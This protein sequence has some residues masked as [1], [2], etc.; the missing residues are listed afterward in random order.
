[1]M[2]QSLILL[3]TSPSLASAIPLILPQVKKEL[4]HSSYYQAD[5]IIGYLIHSSI[6]K[7]KE[8]L[9]NSLLFQLI[10]LYMYI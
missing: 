9:E 1:M 5:L 8:L 7:E 6:S 3:H 4:V 2:I 10:Q